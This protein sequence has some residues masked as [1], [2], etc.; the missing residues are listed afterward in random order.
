VLA[1]RIFG[2][3]EPLIRTAEIVVRFGGVRIQPQRFSQVA[4]LL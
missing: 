3:A 1:Q 4:R 2:L